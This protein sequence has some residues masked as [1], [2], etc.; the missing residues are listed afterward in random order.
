[1]ENLYEWSWKMQGAREMLEFLLSS[2]SCCKCQLETGKDAKVYHEAIARLVLKSLD[3]TARFL[4]GHGIGYFN[5]Q[6]DKKGRLVR[7]DAYF[8]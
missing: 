7:C 5:W 6:H 1:M 3:N 4:A 2:R 8:L